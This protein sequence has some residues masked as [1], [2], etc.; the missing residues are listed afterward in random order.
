MPNQDKRFSLANQT[1]W[2]IW[3]RVN[4]SDAD[5]KTYWAVLKIIKRYWRNSEII[6]SQDK[7]RAK[8]MED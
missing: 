1:I 5:D 2:K 4:G 3:N 7:K 6:T 8:R